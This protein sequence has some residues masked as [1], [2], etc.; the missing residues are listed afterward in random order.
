MLIITKTSDFKLQKKEK[1][2][3]TAADQK[4]KKKEIII[5]ASQT[6]CLFRERLAQD[7]R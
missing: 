5:H 7:S 1:T 6:F 2:C 4:T 3:N